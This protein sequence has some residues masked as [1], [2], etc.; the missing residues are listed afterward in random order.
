MT[1]DLEFIPRR[2]I[3]YRGAVFEEMDV[4]AILRRKP[5]VCLVDEFAHTNV[6]GSPRLKRWEDVQVLL[7]GGHRCFHHAQRAASGKPQRRGVA[8]HRRARARN[9][10][11]LGGGCGRR[12]GPGGSDGGGLAESAGSRRGLYRRKS[13]EGH[14]E[15]LHRSESDGLTGDGAPPHGARSGR[16]AFGPGRSGARPDANGAAR[17]RSPRAARTHSHLPDGAAVDRRADPPRKAGGGLSA[18]RLLGGARAA[19]LRAR[20][21]GSP[22]RSARK[23]LE[24][25]AQL[26]Y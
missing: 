15:L 2:K 13:Q 12:S 11:G 18:C 26:A 25:R 17:G 23:A 6:P 3:E 21:A 7:A 1:A 19:Q 5:A 9:P 24:L 20:R 4:D 16:A 14:G 10:P 22:Q 8:Y